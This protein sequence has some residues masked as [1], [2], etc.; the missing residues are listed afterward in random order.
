MF[1]EVFLRQGVSRQQLL[2]AIRDATVEAKLN[3]AYTLNIDHVD[4]AF[5]SL[6]QKNHF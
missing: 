5:A 3:K 4:E 1:S 2:R 6:N